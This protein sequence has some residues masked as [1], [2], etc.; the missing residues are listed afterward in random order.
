MT[1]IRN[2]VYFEENV[3]D[4]MLPFTFDLNQSCLVFIDNSSL[5]PM[6]RTLV[7][8][9]TL[10]G[11]DSETRPSFIPLQRNKTNS[12]FEIQPMHKTSLL[13]LAIRTRECREKVLIIDLLRLSQF[14]NIKSNGDKNQFNYEKSCKIIP[15]NNCMNEL[16]DILKIPFLNKN[17][18]KIGQSLLNDF[19][20][21]YRSHPN[22]SCFMKV[23]NVIEMTKWYR[24]LQPDILHLIS[25]KNLV[26]QYLHFNLIKTQQCSNWEIRPLSSDQLHYAACD[27]LVLIRL[28]DAMLCESEE[29]AV[30][31]NSIFVIETIANTIDLLPLIKT[32]K[33]KNN[34]EVDTKV[35]NQI[36]IL[37]EHTNMQYYVK[38]WN[39]KS[40][41][42]WYVSSINQE[43]KRARSPTIDIPK[44]ENTKY[45]PLPVSEGK[46]EYFEENFEEKQISRKKTKNL[47]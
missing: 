35:S 39:S 36:D 24:N 11:I 13:Q 23:N 42:Q 22:M 40:A 4:R 8:E 47:K 29:K 45:L 12:F 5:F 28:Y 31:N 2:K 14:D 41:K 32:N 3:Q 1:S 27:A 15:D 7:N 43:N 46:H 16:N 25:L 34:N 26:K 38:S 20:E 17:C 37:M 44:E 19:K 30:L 18:Y 33:S 9:A 6:L 10:I 21:L